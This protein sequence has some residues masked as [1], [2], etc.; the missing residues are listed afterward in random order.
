MGE[1]VHDGVVMESTN[2]AR[3]RS[4]DDKEK[5]NDKDE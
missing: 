4:I 5:G 1:D 3:T 2:A